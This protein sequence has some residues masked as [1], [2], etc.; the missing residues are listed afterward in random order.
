MSRLCLI[1]FVI[2]AAAAAAAV[3]FHVPAVDLNWRRFP[4]HPPS[5]SQPGRRQRQQR[6]H[7][8][9]GHTHLYTVST[10]IHNLT[11]K[12]KHT[13]GYFTSEDTSLCVSVYLLPMLSLTNP[14]PPTPPLLPV[15][16]VECWRCGPLNWQSIH[17]CVIYLMGRGPT[18][19][20]WC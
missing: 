9:L 20:V 18:W 11:H 1:I 17:Q 14:H 10:C 19:P 2:P 4:S 6:L 13:H 16:A 8:P 5:A 3:G 12:H 7:T 15:E